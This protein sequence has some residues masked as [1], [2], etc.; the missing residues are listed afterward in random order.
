MFNK[1]NKQDKLIKELQDDV[2]NSLRNKE[3]KKLLTNLTENEEKI[4]FF[5]WENDTDI[6]PDF[7]LWEQ[8]LIQ[9]H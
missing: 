3:I 4:A 1:K 6:N 5:D 7:E 8:E 2:L 9:N